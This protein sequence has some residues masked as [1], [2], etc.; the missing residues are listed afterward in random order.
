MY[1]VKKYDLF[2]NEKATRKGSHY[3]IFL[4]FFSVKDR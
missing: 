2:Y 1:V 3:M 4:G